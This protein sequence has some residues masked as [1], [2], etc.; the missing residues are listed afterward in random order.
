MTRRLTGW[1]LAEIAAA[2]DGKLSGQGAV[3]C[4]STDSRTIVPGALF[5]ALVGE[6]FD[7]HQ[8][9]SAV[10]D[11]GAGAVVISQDIDVNCPKILVEDTLVALQR[12]ASALWKQAVDGGLGSVA[13]TGSNGKTTTKELIAAIFRG[14][15]MTVHATAGNLNNHI[16][17]PLTICDLPQACDVAVIEMGANQFG[18]ISELIHIAPADVRLITSIGAAHLEILGD[19]DG[20]RRVKSEIFEGG[21]AY[22]AV[23]PA[24]EADRL[25][26]AG[27]LVR[28]FGD[29]GDFTF[30]VLAHDS[31]GQDVQISH[32]DATIEFRLPFL[33]V[34]NASNLA[35]AVAT[36]AAQTG[37][38]PGSGSVDA[39]ASLNLPGGRFR[40]VTF[41]DWSFIDDA[42]N[43]NPTSMLASFQAFVSQLNQ[44]T[45]AYAVVGEMLELGVAAESMHVQTAN[46]MAQIG[47]VEEFVFVG[48]F[49]QQMAKASVAQGVKATSMAEPVDVARY[50]RQNQPGVVF[51]KAS[52]GAR[53]ERVIDMITSRPWT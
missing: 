39:V 2:M 7:G 51:L 5:V 13:L 22:A 28:T 45:P 23:V 6:S 15:G 3:T 19:L 8:F 10:A 27:E 34:H 40:R 48:R 42:Y 9:A 30:K 1:S 25:A 21:Q 11:K 17:V 33:G 43:A 37:H 52:R 49:S 31:L 16:G 32:R 18:D 53:L 47:G 24:A 14:D 41:E 36:F 4:V 46:E 29:N 50:L 44:G 26:T 12:L 20:V 38:L 35:A